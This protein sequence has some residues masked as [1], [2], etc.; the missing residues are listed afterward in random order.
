MAATFILLLAW[1]LHSAAFGADTRFHPD[2]ALYMT[3][4]RS[5]AIQGDWLLLSVPQDKPPLTMYLNALS[6]ILFGA[7]TDAAGVLHLS[8]QQGEFAGRLV[9]MGAALVLVAIVMALARS[10]FHSRRAAWV[11]GLLIAM[12]PYVIAF[13]PTAFTDLP[14]TMF[15]MASVLCAVQG[16]AN[17]AGLWGFLALASKP[18]GLFFL[19]LVLL[20]LWRMGPYKPFVAL[21]PWLIGGALLLSWDAVRVAQGAIDVWTLGQA[22]YASPALATLSDWG[23]RFGRW[24][25]YGQELFGPVLTLPLVAMATWGSWHLLKHRASYNAVWCFVW[26]LGYSA[27]HILMT[28]P[29]Y[30]RYLL[31]T[32]PLLA[33]LASYTLVEL[34]HDTRWRRIYKVMLVLS[35]GLLL[36]YSARAA[37]HLLP[38]GGDHGQNQSIDELADYLND[39]AIAAVIYDPWL[40]WELNYYLG[41]WTNKRRVHYPTPQALV[42]DALQLDESGVRYFVAPSRLNIDDWLTVIEHA[43]FRSEHEAMIGNFVV[44]AL[45]PPDH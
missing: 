23:P 9:S 45:T 37:Q 18:Q 26:V 38:I 1:A 34:S 36:V 21:I 4:A 25:T 33:I 15:G 6:I 35:M 30:D 39:K 24:L 16:R 31:P 11:A 17:W 41:P 2:E 27:V 43:G 28:V 29:L 42:K 10:L 32:A 5:A 14:M 44:V 8:A 40:G 12:S 20:I 3:A 13:G 7:D 22:H 19:P